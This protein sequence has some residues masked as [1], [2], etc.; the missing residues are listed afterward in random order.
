MIDQALSHG[1]PVIPN[2]SF[3]QSIAAVVDLVMERATTRAAEL[4]AA[5]AS[6]DEAPLILEDDEGDEKKEGIP[7]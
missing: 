5:A 2:Y 3:D 4:R 7:A 6:L 1:V